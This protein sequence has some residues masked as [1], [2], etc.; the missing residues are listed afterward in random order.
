[1]LEGRCNVLL[2]GRFH[3]AEVDL[4]HLNKKCS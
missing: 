4:V 3:P 1:M 2:V